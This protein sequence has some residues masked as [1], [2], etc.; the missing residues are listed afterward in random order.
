LRQSLISKSRIENAEAE[1]LS[2]PN[3]ELL[4]GGLER[5]DTD[6]GE[7][8]A[9]FILF[10]SPKSRVLGTESSMQSMKRLLKARKRNQNVLSF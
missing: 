3:F 2:I 9:H 10:Y 8:G 4:V 7:M 1:R 5:S 6:I